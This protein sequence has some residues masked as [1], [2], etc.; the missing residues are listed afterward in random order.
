MG[1]RWAEEKIAG[2]KP[3]L[4]GGMI[5]FGSAGFSPARVGGGMRWA[6]ERIAGVKPALPGGDD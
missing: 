1:M 2:V 3:A 5:E 4:P 6:E